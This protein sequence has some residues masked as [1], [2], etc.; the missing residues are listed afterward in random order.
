MAQLGG[1]HDYFIMVGPA[2]D[3]A[4]TLTATDIN[5]SAGAIVDYRRRIAARSP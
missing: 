2:S 5:L 4:R 3:R 1:W